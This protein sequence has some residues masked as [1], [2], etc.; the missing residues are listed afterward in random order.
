M[1]NLAEGVQPPASDFGPM[2]GFGGN[3][4]K[5]QWKWEAPKTRKSTSKEATA[6]LPAWLSNF[7]PIPLNGLAAA[8]EKDGPSVSSQEILCLA[9]EDELSI[10]RESLRTTSVDQVQNL[11]KSFNSRLTQSIALGLVPIDVLAA[12]LRDVTKDMETLTFNK[13]LVES[14][15]FSFITAVWDGIKACK[16]LRPIDLGSGTL[17]T[18]LSLLAHIPPTRAVQILA[19]EIIEAGTSDLV[20]HMEHGILTLIKAWVSSWICLKAY[21]SGKLK[22]RDQDVSWTL[23]QSVAALAKVIG[24][25]PPDLASRII[26]TCTDYVIKDCF[27]KF[28]GPPGV[29]RK[30]RYSWLSAIANTSCVDEELLIQICTK[31]DLVR[32]RA[33][34]FTTYTPSIRRWTMHD[35][36]RLL[37]DFWISHG[38]MQAAE[39]VKATFITAIEESGLSDG[40]AC[41]LLAMYEHKDLCWTKARS[42][43][44]FLRCVNRPQAVYHSL[45]R[46]LDHNVRFPASDIALEIRDMT[47]IDLLYALNIYKLYGTTLDNST[48]P[49]LE[50][51][52]ELFIAMIHSD[53]FH[54]NDVWEA[55]GISF[56]ECQQSSPSSKPLPEARV[57]LINRIALEF[58][59]ADCRSHRVALR[60]VMQCAMYLRR[61]QVPMSADLSRA[62]S[63]A[64]ITRELLRQHWVGTEKVFW[65]LDQIR[66]TEG[67][68]VADM[69]DRAVYNW[70]SEHIKKQQ[71]SRREGNPMR[72]GTID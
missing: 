19:A 38:Q 70:R 14:L 3:A 18:L 63:Y 2:W 16:V 28:V 34:D 51:C 36:C 50:E 43:F 72:V 66:Q 68:A 53:Q 22:G 30:L 61:H 24:Q 57:K 7:E 13:E 10:F 26:H 62:L 21:E 44:Q 33:K 42:L 6:R 25:L 65:I 8:L 40:A 20:T 11:C 47:R 31:M 17:N 45:R 59:Q 37:L 48:P 60:H 41:L 49:L 32:S 4:N 5:D 39:S 27:A 12:N 29:L 55:M 15:C 35:G 23:E 58:A 46:L 56:D 54:P 69:V 52:Q 64:G 1:A 9:A 67:D 71:F